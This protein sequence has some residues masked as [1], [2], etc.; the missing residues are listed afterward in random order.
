[1]GI[2]TPKEF[3]HSTKPDKE[4]HKQSNLGL[5]C[6]PSTLLYLNI[7]TPKTISFPLGTNVKL[8]LGDPIL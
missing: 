2:L 5:Y 1:M 4:A 6:L 3:A 8:I 7:G